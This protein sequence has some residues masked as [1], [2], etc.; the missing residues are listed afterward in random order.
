ML[1]S[2]S[3]EVCGA[4]QREGLSGSPSGLS[5]L[6][7]GDV[8]LRQLGPR[9]RR[10]GAGLG[11]VRFLFV[12][13][14]L[15]PLPGTLCVALVPL[16]QP[17]H[18]AAARPVVERFDV[19]SKGFGTTEL[20]AVGIGQGGVHQPAVRLRRIDTQ[21]RGPLKGSPGLDFPPLFQ[22]ARPFVSS[23]TASVSS[24]PSAAA[25]R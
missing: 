5:S 10:H 15:K 19:G 3:A 8:D 17:Q 18:Q 4:D 13:H 7:Q 21:R 2:R 16:E 14:S 12:D 25:T 23:S 20:S 24:A 11:V 6:T 9:T 22:L 1:A